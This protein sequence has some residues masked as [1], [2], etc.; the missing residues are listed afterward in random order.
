MKFGKKWE[1]G[2]QEAEEKPERQ[3]LS[4]KIVLGFSE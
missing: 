1:A 2:S 3:S 4:F